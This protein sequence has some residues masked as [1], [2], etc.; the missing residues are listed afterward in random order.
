MQMVQMTPNARLLK[1]T[2]PTPSEGEKRERHRQKKHQLEKQT[3]RVNIKLFAKPKRKTRR[4]KNKKKRHPHSDSEHNRK[5]LAGNYPLHQQ[6]FVFLQSRHL[7]LCLSVVFPLS[8]SALRQTFRA[9][10][11]VNMEA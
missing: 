10:D 7:S 1:I 4:K 11:S 6:D 8:E 9:L 2:Q 5:M 3:Q